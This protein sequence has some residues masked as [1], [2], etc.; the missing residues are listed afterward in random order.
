MNDV[1]R[2]FIAIKTEPQT[3][4]VKLITL[5]Q[6][7]LKDEDIKWVYPENMHITV[8]FLGDTSIEQVSQITDILK[9]EPTLKSGYF[10]N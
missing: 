2:T 6:K 5:F 1:I 7:E 10:K 8:K 3:E 9:I 4:L